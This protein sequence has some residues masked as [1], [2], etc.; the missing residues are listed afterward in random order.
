MLYIQGPCILLL[1]YFVLQIIWNLFENN[2][3]WFENWSVYDKN[4]FETLWKVQSEGGISGNNR[5]KREIAPRD[6]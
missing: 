5:R 2:H 1:Q 3:S 4:R 6:R